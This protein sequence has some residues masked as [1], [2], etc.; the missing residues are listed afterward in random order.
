MGFSGVINFTLGSTI[1]PGG[2]I[3]NAG[4]SP[5]GVNVVVPEPTTF[6]LLGLGAA[7]LLIFRRRK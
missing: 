2:G 1:L 7:G 4:L 6:A 5:M 3:G